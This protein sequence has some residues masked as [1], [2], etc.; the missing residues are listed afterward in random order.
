MASNRNMNKI[1][2]ACYDLNQD[3]NK[4][5]NEMESEL[6]H[7]RKVAE[8]YINSKDQENAELKKELEESERKRQEAEEENERLRTNLEAYNT[9]IAVSSVGA[10]SLNR[11]VNSIRMLWPLNKWNSGP[12]I[13]NYQSIRAYI[14]MLT[15]LPDT[16]F[17]EGKLKDYLDS[18]FIHR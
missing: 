14:E 5:L 10:R 1:I 12:L 6:N 3:W 17:K 4:E 2:R 11:I 13:E 18:N 9:Y 7:C 8:E 16:E 15:E